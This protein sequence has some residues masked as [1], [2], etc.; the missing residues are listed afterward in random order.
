M[1]LAI[2]SLRCSQPQFKPN[3]CRLIRL[4][5]L[6]DEY[7]NSYSTIGFLVGQYRFS[8]TRLRSEKD[9]VLVPSKQ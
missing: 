9:H 1:R 6:F 7:L 2:A 3:F 8:S 4:H 5:Q